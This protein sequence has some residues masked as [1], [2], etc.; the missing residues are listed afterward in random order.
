MTSRLLMFVLTAA[1]V[2]LG[3]T[4]PPGV[5]EGIVCELGQSVLETG[6]LHRIEL[7]F[8]QENWDGL[9]ANA[10]AYGED[11]GT[12]QIY[13]EASITYDDFDKLDGVG[14][15]IK[16]NHAI[17]NAVHLGRSYPLKVDIDRFAPDQTLDGLKKLNLH[18][19]VDEDEDFWEWPSDPVADHV[20]YRAMRDHGAATPRAALAE[21]FINGESFGLY[22]VVEQVSGTFVQCHLPEPWGDLYKPEESLAY[23]GDSIDD[24]PGIEHK[25]PDVSDHAA[26]LELI[27]VLDE[28]DDAELEQVL[29]V[30]GALSYFAF[31]IGLGNWDYY[32]FITHNYYL[33]EAE[34]GRFTVIPWDMNMSQVAWTEPCGVGAGDDWTP[35]SARLLGEE[36]HVARYEQILRDFLEGAGS[37]AAQHALVDEVEPLVS[38]WVPADRLDQL[39]DNIATRVPGLLDALDGLT[40]CPEETDWEDQVE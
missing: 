8:T 21:V 6:K 37:V 33:Y 5:D 10:E 18:A 32:T 13:F 14:V 1:L 17:E 25:W 28:G 29:D 23:E 34:P 16:G 39:R 12:E 20:S 40:V 35:L 7:T 4:A 27:R 26:V 9:V 15:R 11:E 19:M 22:S 3:C 30:D 38:P 31:N 24:Y 36:K 2:A